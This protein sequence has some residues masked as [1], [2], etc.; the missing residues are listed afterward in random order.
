VENTSPLKGVLATH[1]H[2]AAGKGS[3]AT[4]TKC[5]YA[6]TQKDWRLKESRDADSNGS[7]MNS[8]FIPYFDRL[9]VRAK[10][11]ASGLY[12]P[13]IPSPTRQDLVKGL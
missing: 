9:S 11:N 13:S 10:R 3:F 5:S 2:F 8:P 6:L 12:L 4:V 7:S 1:D